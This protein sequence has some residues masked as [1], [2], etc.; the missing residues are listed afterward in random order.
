MIAL[1]GLGVFGVQLVIVITM[2]ISA[3]MGR[4]WLNVVAIGWSAFTLFGSIFTL[5]L[6]LLQLFTIFIGYRVGLWVCRSASDNYG[7]K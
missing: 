4:T 2:V 7:S 5:G 6:L 1:L 3:L